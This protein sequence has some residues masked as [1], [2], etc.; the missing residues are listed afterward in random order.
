MSY[1]YLEPLRNTS[2][3]PGPGVT[4]AMDTLLRSRTRYGGCVE[5]IECPPLVRS[6]GNLDP[7]YDLE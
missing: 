5:T 1:G 3:F 6:V 7:W 2:R 4:D